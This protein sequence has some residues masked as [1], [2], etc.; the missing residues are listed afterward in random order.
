MTLLSTDQSTWGDKR[1]F[2]TIDRAIVNSASASANALRHRLDALTGRIL[3]SAETNSTVVVTTTLVAVAILAVFF[4]TTMSWRNFWRR[5]N[6]A[7]APPHVSDHDYSYI[8]PNDIGP[9]S[10][11]DY[12]DY[13]TPAAARRPGSREDAGARAAMDGGAKD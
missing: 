2:D 12:G 1:A 8:T 4:S 7:S 9:S 3:N 10:S 5:N 6:T 11:A 13:R